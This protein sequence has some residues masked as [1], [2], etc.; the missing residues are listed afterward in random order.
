MPTMT[1]RKWPL[2]LL[3]AGLA[4]STVLLY[5]PAGRAAEKAQS[6]VELAGSRLI[7]INAAGAD[8]LQ[9]VKGIG[10]ALAGRIIAYRAEMGPY[11]D[12]EQLLNVRGIG[13]A[14]YEKIR[15]YLTV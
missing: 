1:F 3:F 5:A 8:E 7:D 12:P 6:R 14:K 13:Q 11:S 4:L 15:P 2:C 10:P 9:A